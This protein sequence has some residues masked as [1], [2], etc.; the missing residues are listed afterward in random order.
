MIMNNELVLFSKIRRKWMKKKY[1]FPIFENKNKKGK[2]PTWMFS[3]NK[4]EILPT[5]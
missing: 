1:V 3:Y 2:Q 5:M 4:Q